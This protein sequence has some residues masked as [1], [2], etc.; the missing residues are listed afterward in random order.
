MKSESYVTIQEVSIIPN[1]ILI[2]PIHNR[3]YG[4]SISIVQM[5]S[6]NITLR[7]SRRDASGVDRSEP[8]N[9]SRVEGT[10]EGRGREGGAAEGAGETEE[11]RAEKKE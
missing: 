9:G 8:R 5:Y 3:V 4:S 7:G 2:S 1:S 6:M 10:V 11:K